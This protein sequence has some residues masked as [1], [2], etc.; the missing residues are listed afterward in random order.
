MYLLLQGVFFF[1]YLLIFLHRAAWDEFAKGAV[2]DIEQ[3]GR[4]DNK[5]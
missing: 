5:V 2:S 4:K 3:A 1:A